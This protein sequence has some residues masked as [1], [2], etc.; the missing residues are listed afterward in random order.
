L[1]DAKNVASQKHELCKVRLHVSLLQTWPEAV[2]CAVLVKGLGKN[3]KKETATLYFE[4]ERRTGGGPIV[5][6]F[7]DEE[8]G[9][10]VITYQ[11]RESTFNSE[12]C[13]SYSISFPTLNSS[14][15]RVKYLQI[16]I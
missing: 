15:E 8:N 10:V 9:T 12:N 7:K 4:N 6:F 5:D 2:S 13:Y 11:K 3:T 14:I 1:S 16:V